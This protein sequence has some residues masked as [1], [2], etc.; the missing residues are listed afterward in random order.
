MSKRKIVNRYII[1]QMDRLETRRITSDTYI[2]ELIE[3]I[4]QY[5]GNSKNKYFLGDIQIRRKEGIIT[6]KRYIKITASTT[7]MNIDETTTYFKNEHSLKLLYDLNLKNHHPLVILYRANKKIRTLPIIYDKKYTDREYIESK[8]LEY[9]YDINFINKILKNAQIKSSA[10]SSLD[11]YDYLY[12][13]RESLKYNLPP[14]ISLAPLKKFYNSFIS[15][16]KGKF[17]YFNFR[18]ISIIIKEYEEMQNKEKL[19]E[20]EQNEVLGQMMIKDYAKLIIQDV[21]EELELLIAEG[22]LEEVYRKKLIKAHKT[23][24]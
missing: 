7:L 11:D 18:L 13:I 23:T 12:A 8:I 20:S 10:I 4:K 16:G 15:D 24:K 14:Q 19:E 5:N 22:T 9:G 3:K 1:G 17:N 6:F 21:Y 2:D